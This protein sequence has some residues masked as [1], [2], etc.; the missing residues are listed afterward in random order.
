MPGRSSESPRPSAPWGALPRFAIP[1]PALRLPRR[2]SRLIEALLYILSILIIVLLRA[3]TA[4]ASGSDI[5]QFAGF[6]ET[7]LAGGPC[8]Y[9][10]AS[11]WLGEPWPFPWLYPYGPLWAL[12]LALLALLVPGRPSWGWEGEVYRVTVPLDWVLAV[13]AMLNLGDALVALALYRLAGGGRRGRIAALAYLASPAG[14]YVTG[15]YGMFDQLAAA[16]LVAS[17]ALARRGRH[18][19]GG[20]AA[21]LS[22][23]FKPTLAPAALAVALTLRV[24]G[25]ARYLSGLAGAV[26]ALMAPF[27]VLCEDSVRAAVHAVLWRNEARVP[28]P[29]VYN[30]NWLASIAA[31]IDSRGLQDTALE[32]VRSW[33]LVAAA[34]APLAVLAASR[35]GPAGAALAGYT[36]FLAS[37]WGINYQFI[38]PLA[39]LL[40][41]WL[42]SGEASGG[43]FCRAAAASLFAVASAWPLL[44]PTEFWFTVHVDQRESLGYRIVSA[45]TLDVVYGLPESALYAVVL[46]LLEA[47]VLACLA[48][49]RRG[50][51]G[52][53]CSSRA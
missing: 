39:A 33:A 46:G 49:R 44:F 21:G 22:V 43:R 1:H 27:L 48:F 12:A 26:A 38:L 16:P 40:L 24:G 7:M 45:L 19:A 34:L 9:L 47:A 2:A 31:Y 30:F 51:P 29:P 25:A 37:Y 13:K 32:L 35:S 11:T 5:P 28:E 50:R 8:F 15:V 41:A 14:L 52:A 20:V 17:I 3:S 53:P 18:L 10:S 6:A 4:V 36:W 23:A 42:S